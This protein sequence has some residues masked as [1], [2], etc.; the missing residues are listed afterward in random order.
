MEQVCK[1]R[2]P[3]AQVSLNEVGDPP[4]KY[5]RVTRQEGLYTRQYPVGLVE[6]GLTL[7]YFERFMEV[8]D[9]PYRDSDLRFVSRIIC[10]QPPEQGSAL[11][12]Q[13]RSRGC[14]V[15]SF[16]EYQNLIDFRGYL[17]RQKA[18]LD[19]DARYPSELFVPQELLYDTY[20]EE[21]VDSDGHALPLLKGKH[22]QNAL[23][24]L[25][26]WLCE[27][28]G[29]FVLLLGEFG[30]GKSFLLRRL[31][32]EFTHRPGAPV[33]IFM[34]LRHLEK[35]QRS[36]N[37]FLVNHLVNNGEERFNVP[38][39]RHMV[40]TGQVVLL[41][42]G[43]DELVTRITYDRAEAHLN[44][45]M[46]AASGQAK[47]VITSR[48]QHFLT[49][50]QMRRAFLRKVEALPG[51]RLGYLQPF[52]EERI[53]QFLYNTFPE[54]RQADE[55]FQLLN[56][57]KDLLGLSEIPRML[58]FIVELPEEQLR[59]ARQEHGEICPADLYRLLIQQWLEHDVKLITETSGT[60]PTMDV[61]ER[62]EAVTLVALKMWSQPGAMMEKDDL[63]SIAARCSGRTSKRLTEGHVAHLLGARTLL[64]RDDDGCFSFVHRSVMEWLVAYHV[65]ELLKRG[66][67]AEP[68]SLNE[69]TPLMASFLVDLIDRDII[70]AWARACLTST[71]DRGAHA[72]PNAKQ[73][74]DHLGLDVDDVA[75]Q[76]VNLAGEDL[77][78]RDFSGQSLR[79][80]NFR[81]ANLAEAQFRDADLEGADLEG[82]ILERADLARANLNHANLK[83]TRASEASLIEAE[84]VG[85]ELDGGM[86]QRTRL[87]GA[88]LEPK[89]MRGWDSSGAAQPDVLEWEPMWAPRS[90]CRAV[91]WHGDVLAA[92]YSDGS[93]VLWS[94]LSKMPLRRLTGHSGAVLSVCYSP[95]GTRLAS[96][97]D[98]R[99]VR[100]WRAS[101]GEHL[102]TLKGHSGYVL[103]V[104]YSPDGTRLTSAGRDREVRVWEAST[105]E[106]LHTFEGHSGHVLSVCYSPDGTRLASSG[107]DREVR[108]WEA[109]TGEHLHTLEGHLSHVLS[110]CYSP[111]GTRL[112]SAGYDGEVRVWHAATGE[113][114]H[115]LEGHSGHVLSVCYSPDST[116]LA[117]AGWDGEVRVWKAVT[118]EHLHTL[119]GH[120]GAVLSV[121]YSP[122]GTRLASAGDDRTVRVWEAS[123]GEHLHTLKGHSVAV[124]SVCYSPDGTRLASAGRDGTVRIWHTAT[125]KPLATLLATTNGWIAFTPSGRYRTEGNL[126]GGF[127][128]AIGLCRFEVGELDP[129]VPSIQP[130]PVG[131][132]LV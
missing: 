17:K 72:K 9:R 52:D 65:A 122:D 101:T 95:D 105:G 107:R 110:V 51:C 57:I 16:V 1:L 100:V 80:A 127:W 20:F 123:T 3:D 75:P 7:A 87:T 50:H 56:D 18:R 11:V 77:R 46:Q 69:V 125:A 119:E 8:V 73:I 42:D 19:G 89:S 111:D 33:P 124:L 39:L 115:T 76:P 98:D 25:E 41:F 79:G 44:T 132:L 129:W 114:L 12:Q 37:G 92:G 35:S 45:L 54:R 113:H 21:G 24:R 47:L 71:E 84:L 61:E 53:R 70:L 102:H 40:E 99:T 30:T 131:Q 83:E 91:A 32:Q 68:L 58:S 2:F 90:P 38:Q 106:H 14:E 97:G 34:E 94:M 120:S 15:L 60:P 104:C 49:D 128:H 13:A 112:A 78:G 88:R 28:D 10:G 74:L 117:S 109:S 62:W 31:A 82:A 64:V 116:R 29:R 4:L 43:F 126:A 103:S 81:G 63:H 86:W 26:R 36:V 118:G 130:A 22:E 108:V 55:R 67:V 23:S 66:E 93:I 96:A 121:C 85:V 6:R 48:T 5:L 27:P 59:E